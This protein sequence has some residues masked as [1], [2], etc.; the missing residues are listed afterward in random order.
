[1]IREA[2]LVS[3]LP[4][5]MREFKETAAALEAEN[6]EFNSVW[7]AVDNVLCNEFIETADEYGISRFEAVLN[8]LPL[9][10]DDIET[11]RKRVQ[12]RWFT[13]IPYTLKVLILKLSGVCGDGNF[14]L[15]TE[16]EKYRIFI[17][18]LD[19]INRTVLEEAENIADEMIP[20]NMEVITVFKNMHKFF[21][22]LRHCE[23]R[24]YTHKELR[25]EVLK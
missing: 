1:M 12:A 25:D 17:R 22:R 15:Y 18:F 3:Y 5:F 21:G 4:E 7:K 24:K 11:R 9:A 8:I 16:Y 20:V 13:M 2:D 14:A 10:E 23:M 6:P 19:D